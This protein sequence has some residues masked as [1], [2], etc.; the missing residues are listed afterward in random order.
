[1]NKIIWDYIRSHREVLLQRDFLIELFMVPERLVLPDTASVSDDKSTVSAVVK[2]PPLY[3]GKLCVY[4]GT[5]WLVQ[6][7]DRM[8][9]PTL[10]DYAEHIT[11]IDTGLDYDPKSKTALV[12]GRTPVTLVA[13]DLSCFPQDAK[14]LKTT[15]GR[16]LIHAV[17]LEDLFKTHY[18]YLNK[19]IKFSDLKFLIEQGFEKNWFDAI[20]QKS[21]FTDRYYFLTYMTELVVP[22]IT[23]KALAKPKSFDEER[24]AQCKLYKDAL[25]KG[26]GAAM[27]RIEKHMEALN[28][29]YLK[30]DKAEHI[31]I[32]KK[33][34]MSQKQLFLTT[35]LLEIFGEPGKVTFAATPLAHGWKKKDFVALVNE[36]R[37]G[38]YFRGIET[39]N[40]GE[41]AK[42]VSLV[43]QDTYIVEPDCKTTRGMVVQPNIHNAEEFAGKYTIG[44]DA[45]PLSL[46]EAKSLA[47]KTIT[48]R[49]PQYCQSKTGYCAR[50]MGRIFEV[51]GQEAISMA[52]KNLSSRFTSAA[53]KKIHATE[54]VLYHIE[55]LNRFRAKN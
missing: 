3:P 46:E 49:S 47:G 10:E 42:Y 44:K 51:I 54:K 9:D 50:C 1:M 5:F 14:P 32:D 30:G 55:D 7:R 23:R 8:Y 11:A 19:E 27:V 22:G 6:K 52:V 2:S 39:A 37:Q 48:L 25:D 12:D 24:A 13:G 15:F 41:D 26:D 31:F 35:G 43:L 28:K 45:H 36:A 18:T 34:A 21:L 53:L 17:L 40:G 20:S 29:E 33:S 4:K 16:Y 38:S